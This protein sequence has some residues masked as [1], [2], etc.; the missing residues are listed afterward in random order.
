MIG[1][2]L[3]A[4][5]LKSRA[6]VGEELPELLDQPPRRAPPPLRLWAQLG[7]VLGRLEAQHDAPEGLHM[8]ER[9][10]QRVHVASEVYVTYMLIYIMCQIQCEYLS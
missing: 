8:E 3:C 5:C 9:L 1:C 4:Y 2:T 10:Q 6:T 7:R